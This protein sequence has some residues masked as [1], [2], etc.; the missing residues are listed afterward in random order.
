MTGSKHRK[1]TLTILRHLPAH[2]SLLRLTPS[3]RRAK[4]FRDPEVKF[5]NRRSHNK[6]HKCQTTCPLDVHPCY[7][8]SQG[9]FANGKNVVITGGSFYVINKSRPESGGKL[10]YPWHPL[11]SSTY[12]FLGF[13]GWNKLVQSISMNF[14]HD[15]ASRGNA[16][17]ATDVKHEC[18]KAKLMSIIMEDDTVRRVVWIHG[19]SHTSE[20]AQSITDL[21]AQLSIQPTSFFVKRSPLEAKRNTPYYS[22]HCISVLSFN[23]RSATPGWT[24]R[25]MRPCYSFSFTVESASRVD[26]HSPHQVG[27]I[28]EIF[29]DTASPSHYP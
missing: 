25:G 13:H 17:R 29:S 22:H 8:G 15:S 28:S 18:V 27:S 4:K 5:L 26:H 2:L 19:S 12:F 23:P 9:L 24:S 11:N 1:K 20:I 10:V 6:F 7:C 16:S 14:F 21:C 3:H